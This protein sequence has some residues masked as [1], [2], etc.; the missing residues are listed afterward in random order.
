MINRAD[1]DRLRAVRATDPAVVSVYLQV[2]VDL[3]EHR[4]LPVRARDL[5]KSA[6]S[7]EPRA[8]GGMVRETDPEAIITAVTQDSHEWLGRTI[9][10]FACAQIEMFDNSPGLQ[11]KLWFSAA[12]GQ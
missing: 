6:A 1:A 8:G 10:L 11:L 7:Q 3:A 9:A 2:P 5:I 4:A 12:A